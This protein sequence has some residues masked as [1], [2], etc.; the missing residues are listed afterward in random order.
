V[1]NISKSWRSS[2]D[3]LAIDWR[4]TG[5]KLLSVLE[6]TLARLLETYWRR[7]ADDRLKEL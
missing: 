1:G 2:R 6:A 4:E 5:K 3:E 7:I